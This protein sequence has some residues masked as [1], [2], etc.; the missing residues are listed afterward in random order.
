MKY[1]NLRA[2]PRRNTTASSYHC[3]TLSLPLVYALSVLLRTR[4]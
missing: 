4:Q 3:L 2:W 1:Y